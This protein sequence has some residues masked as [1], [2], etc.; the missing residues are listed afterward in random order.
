M[1]D[2]YSQSIVVIY[3]KNARVIDAIPNK[4]LLGNKRPFENV[5]RY[6]LVIQGEQSL[7]KIDS[8]MIPSALDGEGTRVVDQKMIYKNFKIDSWLKVSSFYKQGCGYQTTIKNLRDKYK[9]DWKPTGNEDVRFGMKCIEMESGDNIAWFT[10]DIPVSDGPDHGAYGLPG[11]VLDF[12][13]LTT[14]ANWTALNIRI[15]DIEKIEIP[16]CKFYDSEEEIHLPKMDLLKS[17]SQGRL[18]NVILDGYSPRDQWIK[19]E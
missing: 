12:H 8:V 2:V 3:E 6:S 10:P 16:A 9:W 17:S 1:V 15:V 18:K 19:I 5:Q 11:L 4:A 13:H 14:N 7:F